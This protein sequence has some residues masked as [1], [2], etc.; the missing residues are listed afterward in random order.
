MLML[1]GFCVIVCHYSLFPDATEGMTEQVE[2]WELPWFLSVGSSRAH[3]LIDGS[4]IEHGGGDEGLLDDRMEHGK[5][6]FSCGEGML[7]M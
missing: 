6:D 1:I 4:E 5:V 7:G 3:S 2:F